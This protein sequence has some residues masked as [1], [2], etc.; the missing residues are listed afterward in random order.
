MFL[1]VEHLTG[2]VDDLES[3]RQK[4][5]DENIKVT[6]DS[7]TLVSRGYSH[8]RVQRY[9]DAVLTVCMSVLDARINWLLKLLKDDK[10][11]VLYISAYVIF[12]V[13]RGQKT[14]ILC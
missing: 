1:D 9:V 8:S 5:L 4:L 2:R 3:E 13:V 7:H 10:Y 11:V 14:D 12:F 6:E